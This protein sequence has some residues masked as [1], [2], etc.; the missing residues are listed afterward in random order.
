MLSKLNDAGLRL[1][2]EKCNFFKNSVTY[3]G[4][5]IN[6]EGLD[7]CTEKLYIVNVPETIKVTEAKRFL[8]MINYYRN[9]IPNVSSVLRP[10]HELLHSG[11]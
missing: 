5:T 6:K 7:T 10:L 4:Y 11:F 8:G 9:F 2:K 1:Q 3:L